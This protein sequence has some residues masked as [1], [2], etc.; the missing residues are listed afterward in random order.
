[1]ARRPA[2]C[3]GSTVGWR[4]SSARRR[5]DFGAVGRTLLSSGVTGVTDMTPY[6]DVEDFQ[7]IADAVTSGELAQHVMVT[8]SPELDIGELPSSLLIGPAKLLLADH[9]LPSLDDLTSSCG[10][11]GAR[12]ARSRSTASHECRWS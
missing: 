8:G 5:P 2:G 12:T 7:A 9:D 1:M 10:A 11:P 3:G 4:R 6:D